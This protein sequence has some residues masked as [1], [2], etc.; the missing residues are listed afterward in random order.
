MCVY[1]INTTVCIHIHTMYSSKYALYIYAHTYCMYVYIHCSI[2]CVAI[3][4]SDTSEI[5]ACL[6]EQLTNQLND[7]GK[8]KKD[9]S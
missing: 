9:C 3:Y 1:I 8:E 2:L 6:G 5:L 7:L 4:L